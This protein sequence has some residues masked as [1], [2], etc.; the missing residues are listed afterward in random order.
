M[1]SQT[2]RKKYG[3]CVYVRCKD[4]FGNFSVHLLCSKSRVAPVKCVTLPRLELLEAVLLS[5][6]V[7]KALEAMQMTIDAVHLYTDSS[8]VLSWIRT[9]P[10]RLKCFVAN[11]VIQITDLTSKFEWPLINS[12]ENPADPLSRGLS[13]HDLNGNNIWWCGPDFLHRDVDFLN[14][15]DCSNTDPSYM[16]ELKPIMNTFVQSTMIDFFDDLYKLSNNYMKFIR[17]LSFLLRF[18]QK[19]QKKNVDDI[20][21]TSREPNHAR[22]ALV[23]QSQTQKFNAELKALRLGNNIPP[24]SVTHEREKYYHAWKLN[25][26]Y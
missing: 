12:K 24:Q 7:N 19:L 6:L 5:K 15:W 20:F 3:A 10:H 26:P 13:I 21:L 23:Q 4:C 9:Q 18:L 16:N 8:I 11:R 17:I 22:D 14:N 2:H 1:D 25:Y